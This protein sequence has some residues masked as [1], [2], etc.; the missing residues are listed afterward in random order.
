MTSKKLTLHPISKQEI[1]N[2][3]KAHVKANPKILSI[4]DSLSEIFSTESLE[5]E[6]FGKHNLPSTREVFATATTTTRTFN[7]GQ[8][9]TQSQNYNQNYNQRPIQKRKYLPKSPFSSAELN[10]NNWWYLDE[11]QNT[12]GP[13]TTAQMD[14]WYD[15]NFFP[16]NLQIKANENERF[17]RIIDLLGKEQDQ[18]QNFY[19]QPNNQ[20]TMERKD[21]GQNKYQNKQGIDN[22]GWERPKN[23]Y[24]E[25][26]GTGFRRNYTDN[27]GPELTS[28]QITRNTSSTKDNQDNL[29]EPEELKPAKKA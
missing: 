27:K 4:I 23:Q 21:Y 1:L 10:S 11:E 7:Q 25:S 18:K 9:Q 2:T 19:R 8:S 15:D 24:Q 26:E 14:K 16:E 20:A 29:K 22:K 13:F 5:P 12:Q 6:N 17:R 28:M 3:F